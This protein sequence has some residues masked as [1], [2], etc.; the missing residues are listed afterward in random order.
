MLEK[1]MD[2]T[3]GSANKNPFKYGYFNSVCSDQGEAEFAAIRVMTCGLSSQKFGKIINYAVKC[4]D[5]RNIYCEIGTFT[6]YTLLCAALHN[7]RQCLGI[8]NFSST[9]YSPETAKNVRARVHAN[10]GHFSFPNVSFVEEDY[11][12][13]ALDGDRIGV[14]LVD[15]EH[16]REE[17]FNCLEWGHRYLAPYAIVFVDD[18]SACGVYGGVEDWMALHPSEV[19]ELFK[20]HVH[21]PQTGDIDDDELG[22]QRANPVSYN[23]FCILEFTRKK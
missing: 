7:S 21:Y 11:K 18:I 6:G 23:G 13:V 15:A 20:V 14:F 1:D 19:R 4:M 3:T 12:K 22:R 10:L 9:F 8:D 17:C 16:T 5:P 2:L